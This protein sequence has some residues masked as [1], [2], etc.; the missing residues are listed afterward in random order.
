MVSVCRSFF[1]W[2]FFSVDYSPKILA[3]VSS[4]N[5]H[6]SAHLFV[7]SSQVWQVSDQGRRTKAS[8]PPTSFVAFGAG[9]HHHRVR[10]STGVHTKEEK[11]KNG[12]NKQVLPILPSVWET[13]PSLPQCLMQH[14]ILPK[15]A[16]SSLSRLGLV[17]SS[18]PWCPCEWRCVCGILLCIYFP[19]LSKTEPFPN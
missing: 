14:K 4:Q 18:T 11:D 2:L 10:E 13:F 1:P 3:S 16:F 15:K 8:S 5:A 17:V 12:Q 6:P 7:A 9:A 19:S